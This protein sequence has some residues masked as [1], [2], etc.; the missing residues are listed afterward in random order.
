M[1]SALPRA[2]MTGRLTRSVSGWQEFFQGLCAWAWCPRLSIRKKWRQR[3]SHHRQLCFS[4]NQLISVD[5]ISGALPQL[6]FTAPG[7]P[8]R[9]E[10]LQASLSMDGSQVLLFSGLRFPGWT[11]FSEAWEGC[12]QHPPIFETR[13]RSC[14]VGVL[15][16]SLEAYNSDQG[17]MENLLN[18]TQ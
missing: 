16:L 17:S 10:S 11:M 4:E 9:A 7:G 8:C 13:M 14:D 5:H 6:N 1:L 12:D 18:S 3:Y 2:V 15:R